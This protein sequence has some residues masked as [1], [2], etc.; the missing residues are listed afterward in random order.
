MR[1]HARVATLV[2]AAAGLA[3]VVSPAAAQSGA[4]F[5]KGKTITYIVSTGP[6]GGHDYYGRVMARALERQLTGATVVVKNVPGAGHIVGA[7]QIYAARADGLTIGTFSTGLNYAQIVGQS[8]IKF[9]LTR[10]SW[11][12]KQATDTRVLYMSGA[13]PYKTWDDVVKS[14][15]QIRLASSGV[16]SGSHNEA[17]MVGKAFDLNVRVYP[18]YQ[19][20]EAIMGM[21]RGEVD[22]RVGGLTSQQEES[23][24]TAGT[25][26][27][28][29]AIVLQF[30]DPDLK[31]IPDGVKLAQTPIAKAIAAMMVA[32]GQLY[33]VLVGPPDI[34][35]DRLGALRT[36]F[37]NAMLSNEY[38]DELETGKRPYDKTPLPAEEVHK[39][40]LDMINISPEMKKMLQDIMA[41]DKK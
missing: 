21:L 19:G 38:R 13:S 25:D 9:D 34:P 31:D 7:N 22:G 32:E 35:A 41:E 10:M 6:G 15:R 33:R 36:A 24:G 8:A 17:Y 11:I 23:A 2:L 37:R 40:A 5:F 28:D 29:G 12:G 4:D 30:G 27:D 3:A 16:G 39:M 20:A 26:R 18:G 14:P 1:I